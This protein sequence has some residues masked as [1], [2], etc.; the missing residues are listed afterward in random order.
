[1][2]KKRREEK[3]KRKEKNR[4]GVWTSRAQLSSGSFPSMHNALG[5]ITST[6]NKP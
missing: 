4:I 1:M 2:L 3:R 5:S 6:R